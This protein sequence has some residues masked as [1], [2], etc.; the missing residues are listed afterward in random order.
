MAK[1]AFGDIKQA[2]QRK[3]QTVNYEALANEMVSGE[4]DAQRLQENF[5][6]I[7]EKGLISPDAGM[8]IERL[9]NLEANPVGSAF[10][11][12]DGVFRAASTG[13]ETHNRLSLATQTYRLEYA[14]TGDHAKSMQYAEDML[15]K[16]AGDYGSWNSP[17]YANAPWLR[18]GMQFKKFPMRI[19]ANY[20]E[21]IMGTAR[22]DPAK[23]K[24]L[25]FMLAT[26]SVAAGAL[27]LPLGPASGA[28]NAGY[29]L[30]LWDHNWEDVA[31]SMRQWVAGQTSPQVAEVLMHGLPRILGIDLSR[32]GQNSFIFFGSPDSQ[33]PLDN[34]K[35]GMWM[36]AGAPG[37][38]I[39]KYT[40]G[41]QQ[42]MEAWDL[43]KGGAHEQAHVIAIE[44]A[45]NLIQVKMAT[46]IGRAYIQASG[47]PGTKT[48][49]GVPLGN[50]Y[51]TYQAILRAIGI[52]P[53]QE[54]EASEKRS[55]IKRDTKREQQEHTAAMQMFI[56]AN[57][58][59][60]GSIW[61]GIQENYNP[62][63]P[64]EQQITY[65]QLLRARIQAERAGQNDVSGVGAT[66]SRKNRAVAENRSYYNT[67]GP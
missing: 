52:T 27:G 29:M 44:A 64:Q 67:G 32:I 57:D 39:N 25:A 54:A 8:E 45:E 11:R 7:F 66:V 36:L 62:G 5:H 24:Q 3:T 55:T 46:D 15:F 59:E 49:G 4:A 9:R 33:K 2:A 28:V 31:A 10:E 1:A 20:A 21:A 41:V 53:A 13:V 63:R 48:R 17:R 6:N 37:D 30:G 19:M 40:Q 38:M 56:K 14:K 60:L 65:G 23:M 42:A 35:S 47:G 22:G 26:Q 51:N 12:V 18:L 61:R 43:W 34:L 50:E 58:K 16:G